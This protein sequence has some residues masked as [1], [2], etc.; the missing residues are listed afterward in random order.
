MP[1]NGN[2]SSA[3]A[4]TWHVLFMPALLITFASSHGYILLR[5]A[6]GH[7]I[8]RA[9]WRGSKEE[10]EIKAV[11]ETVKKAYLGKIRADGGKSGGSGVGYPFG[12]NIGVD[13]DEVGSD[14]LTDMERLFWR[15]D[16]DEAGVWSAVSG[17][18]E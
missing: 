4:S 15:R 12:V 1:T 8:R 13:V 18:E 7:I 10:K 3:V 14:Q 2:L 9:V 17:K 6:I 5:A 11:S 16:L